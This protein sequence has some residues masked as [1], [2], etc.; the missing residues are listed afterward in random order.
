MSYTSF[1]KP[2]FFTCFTLQ[3]KETKV[4][5]SFIW[6]Q[7]EDTVKEQKVTKLE[8][9][10][11]L[12]WILNLNKCINILFVAVFHRCRFFFKYTYL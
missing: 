5:N 1:L 3:T 11:N 8:A 7:H 12:K 4:N 6:L 9:F 10:Q 2:H